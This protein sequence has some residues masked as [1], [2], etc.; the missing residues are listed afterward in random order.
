MFT[1]ET[2]RLL[3]RP[4]TV[5][6]RPEF[7]ALTSDVEV[8]RYINGGIVYGD[9]EIDEFY[10]RQNRQLKQLGVCMG[11]VIEKSSGAVIGLSGVQQLGDRDD[12]EI[13]WVFARDAWGKGYATEAGGAAAAYVLETLQRPRVVAIINPDNAASKRVAERLGMKY[14][15]RYTGAE[16]GHR[17]PELVVDLFYRNRRSP[18]SEVLSPE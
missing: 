1:L 12:L 15:R 17:K 10:E 6:D 9:A 3:V 5:A 2:E 16:L 13:G 8:L 4:W 7:A 14:D 18:K 11:A